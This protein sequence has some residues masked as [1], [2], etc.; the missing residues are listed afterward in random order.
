MTQARLIAIW[1]VLVAVLCAGLVLGTVLLMS[2]TPSQI[3]CPTC[4]C[5]CDDD[6]AHLFIGDDFGNEN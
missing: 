4:T 6:G 2:P 1:A 5:M 3:R